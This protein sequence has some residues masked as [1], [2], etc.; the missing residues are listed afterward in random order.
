MPQ[1][2]RFAIVERYED[3]AKAVRRFSPGQMKSYDSLYSCSAFLPR[4]V[5]KDCQ[6]MNAFLCQFGMQSFRE[7][8]LCKLGAGIWQQVGYAYLTADR[9]DI[10]NMA[11]LTLHHRW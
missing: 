2:G 9:S 10:H 6:D 11:A 4:I 8:H 3:F 7:A 5:R 1:K